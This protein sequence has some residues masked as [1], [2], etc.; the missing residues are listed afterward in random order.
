MW[1][2]HGPRANIGSLRERI[3]IQEAD[4]TPDNAKQ[5]IATWSDRLTGIPAS[6][7]I[8]SGGETLRG[9]QIEAGVVAVFTCRWLDGITP[10]MRLVHDQQEKTYGIVKVEP[11]DDRRQFMFIQC[12]RLANLG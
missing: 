10:M 9:R 3:S 6:M 5:P 1:K 8:V 4:Y 7:E 2:Y 12:K 11:A